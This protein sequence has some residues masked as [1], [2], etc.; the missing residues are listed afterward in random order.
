MPAKNMT[1]KF[2]SLLAI[3]TIFIDCQARNLINRSHNSNR[4]VE[5]KGDENYGLVM[6]TLTQKGAISAKIRITIK[7]INGKIAGY[8]DANL[9][10]N[11]AHLKMNG[12]AIDFLKL[13]PGIYSISSYHGEM[14]KKGLFGTKLYHFHQYNT[15]F[16]FR[17][18]PGLTA[19]LGNIKFDFSRRRSTKVSVSDMIVRDISW[20]QK[21]QPKLNHLT[22][23]RQVIDP[24]RSLRRRKFGN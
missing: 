7:D 17:V 16:R 23:D 5:F 14:L 20:V 9:L 3:L 18:N 11:N 6:A 22:L 2:L 1:V 12:S 13:K 21:L 10:Q 4:L 24:R 15:S 19:Y 8:I